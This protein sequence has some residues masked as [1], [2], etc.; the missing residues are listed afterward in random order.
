MYCSQ[1]GKEVT[2]NAKFCGAC[3]APISSAG[4]SS[5]EIAQVASPAQTAPP[6]PHQTLKPLVGISGWLVLVALGLLISIAV[7]AYSVVLLLDMSAD[8]TAFTDPAYPAYYVPSLA[9]YFNVSLLVEVVL[10]GVMVHLCVLMYQ[11]K[12]VFPRRYFIVVWALVIVALLDALYVT[13]I[14][15]QSHTAE[16]LVGLDPQDSYTALVQAL[17]SAFVWGTYIRLSKR[18]KNTFVVD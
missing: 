2:D 5:H 3:G 11:R 9:T 18:V 16:I 4:S 10:L 15:A 6:P 12:R 8:A 17:I 1:C 14:D 7:S 13:S